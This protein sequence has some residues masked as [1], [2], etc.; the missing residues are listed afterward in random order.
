MELESEGKRGRGRPRVETRL[1]EGWK[2]IIIEAGKEAHHIR[3]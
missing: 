1:P 2:E 3:Y